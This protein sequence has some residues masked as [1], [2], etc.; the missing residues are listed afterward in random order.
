MKEFRDY[1]IENEKEYKFTIKLAVN[2]VTDCILDCLETCL[3]RYELV[4]A[5]TFKKT[6]IQESPL[7]FPN[8]KNSP[9]YISE[10]VMHYPS[11]TEFLQVHIAN[12]TGISKQS[13]VVYSN[14]DPRQI[15]TD[16]YLARSSDEFKENYVPALG[17]DYPEEDNQWASLQS[18]TMDLL[19]ELQEVRNKRD[20]TVVESPLIPPMS[21][22]HSVL[23]SG[24]SDM[25]VDQHQLGLFGRI[26]RSELKS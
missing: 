1:V 16:L 11:T 25:P 20:I 24:Y 15:E 19:K 2:E 10:I 23:P 3:A 8:V 6:P 14:N 9:V 4:S 12:G 18:Q 17:S 13:V 21:V 26:K 7:D 5:T 22:D